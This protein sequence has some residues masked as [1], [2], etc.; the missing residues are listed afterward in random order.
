ME[1]PLRRELLIALDNPVSI[2]RLYDGAWFPLRRYITEAASI[3]VSIERSADALKRAENIE[4]LFRLSRKFVSGYLLD[5]DAVLMGCKLAI[6]ILEGLPYDTPLQDVWIDLRRLPEGWPIQSSLDGVLALMKTVPS[7]RQMFFDE[8]YPGPEGE[9]LGIGDAA[10][11]AAMAFSIYFGR[12]E[13]GLLTMCSRDS[14]ELA[15]RML[16]NLEEW[17]GRLEHAL[18]VFAWRHNPW[19]PNRCAKS[20]DRGGKVRSE[21]DETLSLSSVVPGLAKKLANG[22]K[23]FARHEAAAQILEVV[24][25]FPIAINRSQ[26]DWAV[27][28]SRGKPT[29]GQALKLIRNHPIWLDAMGC[30]VSSDTAKKNPRLRKT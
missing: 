4:L 24:S 1:N 23:V 30:V 28:L 25:N 17:R 3:V 12:R 7:M 21:P 9:G 15:S 13:F 10:D 5:E 27:C 8:P 29:I 11:Y 19:P 6:F 22:E 18:A 20:E 14:D 2:S 16:P 26:D